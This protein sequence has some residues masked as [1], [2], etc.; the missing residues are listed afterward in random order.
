MCRAFNTDARFDEDKGKWV[1]TH[2]KKRKIHINENGVPDKGNPFVIAKMTGAKP[3]VSTGYKKKNLHDLLVKGKSDKA[4]KALKALE[5][6]STITLEN[7]TQYTK[8]GS[9]FVSSKGKS[10]VK[11]TPQA[12]AKILHGHSG[13]GKDFTIGDP[14]PKTEKPDEAKKEPKTSTAVKLP[15]SEEA[16]KVQSY[17]DTWKKGK[18]FSATKKDEAIETLKKLKDGAEISFDGKTWKKMQ[19]STGGIIE[20][21]FTSDGGNTHK[22]AGQLLEDMHSA[23]NS[24]ATPDVSEPDGS[25]LP[26][27]FTYVEG[28]LGVSHDKH[29][30]N[31]P[32]DIPK[33]PP[34][35]IKTASGHTIVEAGNMLSKFK[36]SSTTKEI[37]EQQGFS[38]LP[39]RVSKEEFQKIAKQS[40]FVSKRTYCA[41]SQELADEYR[42][43]LYNGDFYV[44]CTVGGAQYGQGMYC[45]ADYTSGGYNAGI[46]AEMKH[47]QELNKARQADNAFILSSST[48]D[49]NKALDEL[50]AAHVYG[51][52]GGYGTNGFKHMTPAEHDVFKKW[53]THQVLTPEEEKI[54]QNHG[55]FISAQ[56]I[57]ASN[58]GWSAYGTV[59]SQ[60]SKS[61]TK[62]K[63]LSTYKGYTKTEVVTLDPSAKVISY[64]ALKK[65]YGSYHGSKPKD[66]GAFAAAMGY[67]AINAYGHGKS[68]SY[69]VILNRTKCVFL[70]KPINGDSVDEPKESRIKFIP[71]KHGRFH[72]YRDGQYLGWV[73]T[74]IGGQN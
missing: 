5:E 69:T 61:A 22:T 1:T 40:G 30:G 51:S 6:G 64:P 9:G 44:D 39:R 70:D 2:E 62:N 49:L 58:V 72:A 63:F 57:L 54:R 53:V 46:D 55:G 29:M 16:K 59:S 41:A 67:D 36:S 10:G 28:Q 66:L 15:A 68:G 8:T 13:G 25:T 24:G 23:V 31:N 45:A 27:K 26:P 7:G 56:S 48:S 52:Y 32:I 71:G 3:K 33:G 18:A 21:V 34:K 14:K 35:S 11:Q 20:T 42:N 38:G 65:K 4:V 60:Q 12:I 43:Q 50:K 74:Y 19:A 37:I 73:D 47:Y 17:I